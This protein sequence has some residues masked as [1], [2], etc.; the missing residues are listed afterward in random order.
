MRSDRKTGGNIVRT[1]IHSAGGDS[2]GHGYCKLRRRAENVAGVGGIM[3]E[4]RPELRSRHI[5]THYC[6]D[7]TTSR[8]THR[9]KSG[10]SYARRTI[11]QP[12]VSMI[13]SHQYHYKQGT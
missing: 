2:G 13:R 12:V 6:V 8:P 9:T 4:N 11:G 3:R 1:R 10:Q 5:S 7:V